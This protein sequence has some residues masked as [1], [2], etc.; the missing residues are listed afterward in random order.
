MKIKKENQVFLTH[1]FVPDRSDPI[2]FLTVVVNTSGHVYE[3]FTRLFFFH[4]YRED[5]I[6]VGELSKKSDQFRFLC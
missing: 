3:D 4:T 6:F 5:S 1:K 2:V